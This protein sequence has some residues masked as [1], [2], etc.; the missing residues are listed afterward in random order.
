MLRVTLSA[1]ALLVSSACGP[2]REPDPAALDRTLNNLIAEQEAE[3]ARLV[4]DARLREEQRAREVAERAANRSADAADE[5]G[6]NAA[7]NAQ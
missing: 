4:E 7:G 3:R 5:E 2:D 6:G 1:L